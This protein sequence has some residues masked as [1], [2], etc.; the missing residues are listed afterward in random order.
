M[1]KADK[2]VTIKESQLNAKLDSAKKVGAQEIRDSFK[3]SLPAPSKI[4]NNASTAKMPVK[5]QPQTL[6]F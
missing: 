5:G 2:A 4:R 1:P 6:K 3:R